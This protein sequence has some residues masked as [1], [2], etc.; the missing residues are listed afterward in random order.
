[1][2]VRAAEQLAVEPGQMCLISLIG[3]SGEGLQPV[4]LAHERSG[5]VER[6]REQIGWGVT[7]GPDAFSREVRR[8]GRSLRIP[9]MNPRQLWLWLPQEYAAVA[10]RGGVSGL[11]AAALINRSR[12]VGTVLLWRERERPAFG[13]ADEAYVGALAKRLGLGLQALA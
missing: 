7:P 1:L 8:T 3:G 11:L 4:A 10:E 12:V 2:L 5:A 9:I 6:L 13:E